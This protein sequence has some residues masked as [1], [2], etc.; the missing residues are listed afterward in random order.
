MLFDFTIKSFNILFNPVPR[1]IVPVGYGG[2]SCSTNSGLPSRAARIPSYKLAACQASSC[3]GSF[4]GKLAFMGK[5]V[6]GRFSVFFNS[7]DSD[8]AVVTNC[9]FYPQLPERPLLVN[10]LG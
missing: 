7:N 9:P 8:M 10:S 5:S 2:P 4:C 1:W 3:F 6:F